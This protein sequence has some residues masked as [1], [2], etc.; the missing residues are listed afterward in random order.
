MGVSKKEEKKLAAIFDIVLISVLIENESCAFP[1]SDASHNNWN[2]L[3][4]TS[5]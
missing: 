2:I 3:V 4:Y 5:T 1:H